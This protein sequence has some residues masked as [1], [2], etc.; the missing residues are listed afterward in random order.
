MKMQISGI[1]KKPEET[2]EEPK[3]VFLALLPFPGGATVS[4]V[5]QN[6]DRIS[7]GNLI[8]IDLHC[9]TIA[10]SA[11]PNKYLGFELEDDLSTHFPVVKIS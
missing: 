5:D 6:G 11:C 10:R 2:E 8:E 4:V 3:E 1:Y 7:C 9:M